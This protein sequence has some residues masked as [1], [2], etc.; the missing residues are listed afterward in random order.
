MKQLV[1]IVVMSMLSLFTTAQ[2]PDGP[3]PKFWHPNQLDSFQL[4]YPHCDDYDF[5]FTKIDGVYV[6]PSE[7]PRKDQLVYV[8]CLIAVLIVILLMIKLVTRKVDYFR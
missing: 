2:C 8:I 7:T 1:F 6:K 3:I 4:L 5:Q